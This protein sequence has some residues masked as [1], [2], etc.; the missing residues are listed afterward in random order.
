MT[1]GRRLPSLLL[2]FQPGELRYSAGLSMF[3]FSINGFSRTWGWCGA[4]LLHCVGCRTYHALFKIW[5]VK[6]FHLKVVY[7]CLNV[8]MHRLRKY[9]VCENGVNGWQVTRGGTIGG[10]TLRDC[11]P[12]SFS[13]IWMKYKDVQNPAFTYDTAIT[14]SVLIFPMENGPLSWG[15]EPSCCHAGENVRGHKAI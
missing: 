2:W 9:S 5:S 7:K 13:L 15:Q 12:W 8:V 10:L 3:S 4:W 14:Q 11:F 6:C 1:G